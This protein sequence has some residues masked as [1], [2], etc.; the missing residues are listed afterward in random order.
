M[1]HLYFICMF[2]CISLTG[3]EITKRDYTATRYEVLNPHYLNLTI[4]GCCNFIHKGKNY[5][6]YVSN[7]HNGIHVL[8]GC[9]GYI[10]KEGLSENAF[11]ILDIQTG[12]NT[13]LKLMPELQEIYKKDASKNSS[14][15][16]HM[17]DADTGVID[18][19]KK[20]YIFQKAW[21]YLYLF[22]IF[23]RGMR[24]CATKTIQT[25]SLKIL[26]QEDTIYTIDSSP[27][28]LVVVSSQGYVITWPKNGIF[29][30][31]NE[32]KTV[33][34]NEK[35]FSY[36]LNYTE[37]LLCL[38]LQNGKLFI[39]DLANLAQNK[40]V[41]LFPDSRINI[42]VLS[43]YNDL[44]LAADVSYCAK[45]TEYC[46]KKDIEIISPVCEQCK[47]INY[48]NIYKKQQ[49]IDLMQLD[50]LQEDLKKQLTD[51]NN[52]ECEHIT[53]IKKNMIDVCDY[54]KHIENP[55]D[56]GHS[57]F[58]IKE[59][60]KNLNEDRKVSCIG[61]PFLNKELL[62]P[63]YYSALKYSC[64]STSQFINSKVSQI[65][66][67]SE[68][69][70]VLHICSE[71]KNT[72]NHYIYRGEIYNP[73]NYTL[74]EDIQNCNVAHIVPTVPQGFIVLKNTQD[75]YV[76][77]DFITKYIKN[78]HYSW[79]KHQYNN[80]LRWFSENR[81]RFILLSLCL[82]PLFTCYRGANDMV[83]MVSLCPL[84]FLLYKHS[85]PISSAT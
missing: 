50:Q 73:Q 13:P 32:L 75:S 40:I 19:D 39:V 60:K 82:I 24:E 64:D 16:L 7:N 10:K 45:K 41:S 51:L 52:R 25:L 57:L 70:I 85:G 29:V 43:S 35:F 30:K 49:T 6:M 8:M 9:S 26:K 66:L 31:E 65:E 22:N 37:N 38:G 56:I 1:N 33:Q 78:N 4:N 15:S 77:M 53:S 5:G 21:D 20:I 58:S 17:L 72:I 42:N 81:R 11:S 27:Y 74:V 84:L 28:H 59:I 69:E 80:G 3:M 61:Q 2:V 67:I 47:T 83:C 55:F 62:M 46:C 71:V 36:V 23:E 76:L 54:H 14:F 34:C 12:I 18:H 48:E 63:S 79:F 68:N 44:L